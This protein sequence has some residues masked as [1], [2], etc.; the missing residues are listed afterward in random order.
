M[1]PNRQSA[2][3]RA[4]AL[5]AALLV[6]A[7][8]LADL[9]PPL[10]DVSSRL[11]ALNAVSRGL[12]FVLARQGKDGSWSGHPGI[13]AVCLMSLARGPQAETKAVADAVKRARVFILAHARADGAIANRVAAGNEVYATS[14]GAMALTMLGRAQDREAIIRARGFLM[15][16]QQPSGFDYSGLGSGYQAS[17]YPDL[18]NTHWALEALH[19]SQPLAAKAPPEHRQAAA[20]FRARAGALVAACQVQTGEAAGGFLYYPVALAEEKTVKHRGL[21]LRQAWGS[22]TYGGLKSLAY[23]GVEPTDKR[24]ALGRG[25]L[26]RHFT[27][28]QNH[29]LDQGGLYY[30]YYM[31]VSTYT[32]LGEKRVLDAA[33]R[34]R[35]WRQGLVN[36]LLSRQRGKGEWVN[37]NRLWMENDPNLCT[38]YALLALEIILAGT[39]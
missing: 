24:I 6:A 32:V 35:N 13:T 25:W 38:A 36:E 26:Q 21:P 12:G 1:R 27:W 7:P 2:W 3:R 17:R 28:R 29:G 10:L 18:S 19:L 9:E 5:L 39:Q 4:A 22:L 31:L 23:C 20:K 14:V 34:P 37:Q 8:A 16:R 15:R 33:G 11:E 30:C